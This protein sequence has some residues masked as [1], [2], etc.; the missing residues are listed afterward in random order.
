MKKVSLLLIL[1]LFCCPILAGC[2]GRSEMDQVVVYSFCGESEFLQV[3]NGVMVLTES[4][5]V[6]YGGDLEEKQEKMADIVSYTADFYVL[7]EGEKI[8][9][10]SSGAA[11]M[12]G[13]SLSISGDLPDISGGVSAV[14]EDLENHFYF[15]LRTTDA[16]GEQNAYQIPLQVTKGMEMS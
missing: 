7:S 4:Q 10:L 9:V 2:G 15:E 11:D 12:T 6:L 16:A 5:I 13:G 1:A 8:M 14:R 3:A